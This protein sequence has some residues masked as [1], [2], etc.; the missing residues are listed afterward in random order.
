MESWDRYSRVASD[1]GWPLAFAVQDGMVPAD[2][3][4]AANVVFVGGTTEWKWNT[5]ATWAAA[6]PRVHVGRVNGHAIWECDRLGVESIDGTGWFR[7]DGR[8][9][10]ILK[11]WIER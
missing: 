4:S 5:V 6:F 8:K 10:R 7:D 11:D 3:P 9:G 2:V 1:Y